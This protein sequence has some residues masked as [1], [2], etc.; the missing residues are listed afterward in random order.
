M[1]CSLSGHL[2]QL[3]PACNSVIL[4]KI[5]WPQLEFWNCV[6]DCAQICLTSLQSRNCA[7]C[8]RNCAIVGSQLVFVSV[9][10]EARTQVALDCRLGLAGGAAQK[11]GT[12][13]SWHCHLCPHHHWYVHHHPIHRHHHH[14]FNFVNSRSFH[15]WWYS[16]SGSSCEDAADADEDAPS[17]DG[18]DDDYVDWLMMVMMIMMIDDED[19]DAWDDNYVDWWR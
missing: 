14:E 8:V 11:I 7:V 3:R 17:A 6:N 19:A 13:H 16:S 1:T 4:I 9:T 10:M 2:P 5:L 15:D 12:F 18:C